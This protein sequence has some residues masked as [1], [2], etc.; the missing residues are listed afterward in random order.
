MFM[1]KKCALIFFLLLSFISVKPQATPA[2]NWTKTD[3]NGNSHTLYNYL[4]S[5][6]VAV[7][8]FGM[9]CSSC[10]DAIS[11]FSGLKTQYAI[12]HPGKFKV[13]YLDF[14]AGNTCTAN[15]I[16]VLTG[17]SLDAG[18]DN[19]TSDLANYTNATPMT[20][21]VITAGTSHSIIY[22]IKK[23]IFD[24]ADSVAIKTSID[25]FFNTL[26]VNEIKSIKNSI[27]IY[28]NPADESLKI[29]L[30]LKNSKND[31]KISIYNGLGKLI[32]QDEIS[33]TNNSAI[34]NTKELPN[35]V[36]IL[37]LRADSR[38][39]KTGSSN[40]EVIITK[41]FLIAR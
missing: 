39:V 7:M 40:N 4:D 27:N 15:V 29:N 18:F 32:K 9:G 34:I 26:G 19:C 11:Y 21:L 20:Y 22:S 1:I 5:N 33:F 8:I 3:C 14:F 12:T 36:Y 6:K 23:N 2:T 41:R 17:S 25:D 16:P 38:S 37:S 31:Y 10:I 28:P 13:F 35:G 30:D 24:F